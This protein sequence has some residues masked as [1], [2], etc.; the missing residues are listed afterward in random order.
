MSRVMDD[1][2]LVVD[3]DP[4]MA[5]LLTRHLTRAGYRVSSAESGWQALD[6]LSAEDIDAVVS[7]VKMPGLDGVS[8]M[9]ET[10]KRG[11]TVPVILMTAF[12]TIDNAVEAMRK[13]AFDYL[14]KPFPLENVAATVRRALE[15]NRPRQQD[16]NL[17]GAREG[18]TPF[19]GIIGA[20]DGMQRVFRMIERS[21]NSDVTVLVS[22]PSGTGKEM[23]A[24]AIHSVSQRSA[25]PL[26]IVDCSAMPES[27]F[28]SELFGYTRGSFTGAVKDRAGLFENAHGGTLFLDEIT[29]LSGA[30]QA[31]LLRAIEERSIRRLGSNKRIDI[32]VRFLAAANV[33]LRA[34]ID[35]GRFREDLYFRLNVLQV[36]LPALRDRGEDVLLLA[37]HFLQTGRA[38]QSDSLVEGFDEEAIRCL[39]EYSW[40]GNVRELANAVEQAMVMSPGPLI[41][42]QSLPAEVQAGSRE[43]GRSDDDVSEC[44]PPLKEI[45]EGHIRRALRETDG[46]RTAAAKLLGIDRRT[47]QR[48]L[49]KEPDSES[50]SD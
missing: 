13:G 7:D 12:G 29:S 14:S 42:R 16:A 37:E 47:L 10:R 33:D 40:P 24:R 32:D 35:A 38:G 46:N 49:H 5:R 28:E 19:A 4:N 26:V 8:M 36:K 30:A 3:D 45:I 11:L 48:H 21:A 9:A 17:S 27:L 18:A 39:M 31:K 44:A 6:L 50:A 22:G 2:V 34:E 23:V 43:A 25:E 41:E 20:S 15:K 1:H